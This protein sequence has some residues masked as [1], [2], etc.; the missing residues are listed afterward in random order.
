MKTELSFKEKAVL[1]VMLMEYTFREA[2]LQLD[3]TCTNGEKIEMSIFFPGEYGGPDDF[4]VYLDATCLPAASFPLSAATGYSH[5]RRFKAIENLESPASID[6]VTRVFN[7]IIENCHGSIIKEIKFPI[8]IDNPFGEH[9][10]MEIYS[11]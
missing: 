5:S 11:V 9:E 3:C 1:K 8:E 6:L 10:K 4:K 7:K 2:G